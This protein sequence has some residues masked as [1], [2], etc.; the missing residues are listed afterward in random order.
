MT[1][2]TSDDSITDQESINDF[3]DT[4]S[5]M[6]NYDES[7]FNKSSSEEKEEE[8]EEEENEFE[9]VKIALR[10]WVKQFQI[11]HVALTALLLILR[12]HFCFSQ[13]PKCAKT[14]LKTPRST[15][16]TKCGQ[17]KYWH[18]G[19]AKGIRLVFDNLKKI[20]NTIKLMIGIDGLPTS[21]RRKQFWPI[22][23]QIGYKTKVFIIGCYEGKEKPACTDS[24]LRPFVDEMKELSKSGITIQ[25]H[26]YNVKLNA[27]IFDAVA[28]A[29]IL[30]VKGHVGYSSCTK[31]TVVGKYFDRMSFFQLDCDKR[32]DNEFR[33]QADPKH[34]VKTTILT[35]LSN[36][37][38]V[39]RVPLDYM[40]LICLGLVKKL[41]S[42]WISMKLLTDE[43]IVLINEHLESCNPHIPEEF[44]RKSDDMTV[45]SS[46]KATEGRLFLL[47]LGPVVLRNIFKGQLENVYDNFLSLHIATRILCTPGLESHYDYAEKLCE[48]FVNSCADIFGEQYVSRN[49]H[50]IIHLTEDARIYGT[51]DEFSAFP[52]E[53]YMGSIK[54]YLRKPGKQQE[55]LHRRYTEDETCPTVKI[56]QSSRG[57]KDQHY[58]GPFINKL[59][60]PAYKTYECVDI[61]YKTSAPNNCALMQNN[62]IVIIENFATSQSNEVFVIGK[63]FASVKPMYKHTN[64]SDNL[65]CFEVTSL[66][67]RKM[68]PVSSISRKC[69][70]LPNSENSASFAIPLLH[71]DKNL[72]QEFDL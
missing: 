51:L 39:S 16:T 20:G 71:S 58:A 45:Y 47:Y 4:Y 66:S 5:Y 68:W 14:F 56:T 54:R 59:R 8:E 2:E 18:Y 63:N 53:N 50:G 28:L 29:H 42:L 60:F 26:H 19:I 7:A 49:V 9:K 46:W 36:F 61:V 1:S 48:Y 41:I 15:K 24:F 11:T 62:E 38:M 52:F 21:K 10:L 57:F 65:Q 23:G 69:V 43:D 55:Q 3:I 70:L 25:D 44:A 72:E 33:R 22:L 30:G 40:H 12:A 13:L 37:D 31:C 17:G 35:E 27:M 32:T 34:H 6:P 67:E 64:V